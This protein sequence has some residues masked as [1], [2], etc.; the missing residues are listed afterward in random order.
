MLA[1]RL[2]RGAHPLGQLLRLLV[3]CATAGVG[4]LLL[5]TLT[6][7]LAH[8]GRPDA[9]V[10]LLLWCLVPLAAAV[11]FAVA[12]ARTEP[13]PRSRSALDAAGMGPATLP[14]LSAVSTAVACLL[15]SVVALLV[16]LHLRGQLSGMP[17][18]GAAVG[19][20]AADR[21][22]PL[23]AALTLL[24]IAPVVASVTAALTMRVRATRTAPENH[25]GPG[26]PVQDSTRTTSPQVSAL[27]AETVPAPSPAAL[28][29]GVA[30]AAA[31]L[32][33]ETLA[34]ASS[35]PALHPMTLDSLPAG[36]ALG[37]LAAA[38]GLILT[39]PGL[40]HLSGRLLAAGRPGAARL[41]AGRALQQEAGRI[42]RPWGALCAVAAGGLLT[43]ELYGNAPGGGEADFG[44]L[45]VLG[46]ALVVCCTV[47]SALTAAG[48]TRA[49]RA[50][51]LA[52]LQRIGAPQRVLWAAAALRTG[53]LLAGLALSAWL[54]AVLA[55]LPLT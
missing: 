27:F 4:F 8:P 41:L 17:F 16:F 6:H 37:C 44:P 14:F 24:C 12:V 53:T 47:A 50:P 5:A 42:G 45:P 38:L 15:G 28:P 23:A 29:W 48:E 30:L 43:A 35:R 46:A 2:A 19:L 1:L 54:L 20:L 40:V 52:T 39:G 49:A 9:S 18:D 21:P 13:G 22:L 10:R 26:E 11:Q 7:A 36:V 25:G 32:A 55:A 34:G 33:L 3:A 31:G 51:S